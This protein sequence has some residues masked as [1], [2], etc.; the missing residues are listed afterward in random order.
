MTT[1]QYMN[2]NRTIANTVATAIAQRDHETRTAALAVYWRAVA[3]DAGFARLAIDPL[4]VGDALRVLNRTAADLARDA[5]MLRASIDD[6]R[7][8]RAVDNAQNGV[9]DANAALNA[10]AAK[11]RELETELATVKGQALR[12]GMAH[13]AANKALEQAR[14]SVA[15]AERR[16][17]ELTARRD[18]PGWPALQ[19][20]RAEEAPAPS[21]AA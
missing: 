20:M 9:V 17:A 3:T 13:E 4:A 18:F 1:D 16:C 8:Q 14:Q 5:S 7:L 12:L 11:V 2:T 6:G 15:L 21:G 19:A 10:H